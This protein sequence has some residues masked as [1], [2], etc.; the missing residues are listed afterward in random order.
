MEVTGEDR[1]EFPELTVL[2]G[3]RE[4]EFRAWMRMVRFH[5]RMVRRVEQGFARHGI[6][7]AQFDVLAT[8]QAGEG[9]TQQDLARRLLVTKGNVCG[10]IDRMELAGWVERR[11]DPDDRRA[12]RLFLTEQGRERL[13]ETLPDHHAL[14]HEIL[15]RFDDGQLQA[16]H[17]LHAR[18]EGDDPQV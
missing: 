16:F 14:I 2:P 17:E 18:L 9:I 5:L 6:S 13:A 12:N 4:L 11:A 1:R 3:R 10:L 8:L 7:P 15:G